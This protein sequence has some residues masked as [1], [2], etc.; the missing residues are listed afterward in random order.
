MDYDDDLNAPVWDDLNPP[1]QASDPG[2]RNTLADLS[3]NEDTTGQ[4][5]ESDK[6]NSDATNE[7][8]TWNNENDENEGNSNLLNELAPEEDPLLDLQTANG[9]S[10][11]SSP[12]KGTDDPLFSAS[13]Y[14][15]LIA[16]DEANGPD[17]SQSTPVLSSARKSGKPHM[18]FNSARMRRRP[19]T[20]KDRSPEIADPLGKLKKTSETQDELSEELTSTN[21]KSSARSKTILDQVEEPL[22]KVGSR[23]SIIENDLNTDNRQ[24]GIDVEPQ[25][26]LHESEHEE[27]TSQPVNFNIE[28][29]DPVKV[30]ELTSMHVEYTVV[31]ESDL[32]ETKYAQV[33]RRYT[34]F[35]WLYRQLQS[36]HWG[37]IIP[38]P[39]EK[40]S[41]GRFKQDFIENRRFQMEKM[42]RKIASNRSLQSDPDFILFLTSG[43]FTFDS[44]CR[45]HATGSNASR[46]S[47]DLSEIHISEIELLGAE[48]AAV[49]LKNGGLDGESQKRFL[50]ISFSSLPKYTESDEYF[51]EQ[52]KATENLEE[53]LKQLNKSLDLVDSER[54]ELA[55]VTEEFS[56]TI[57]ALAELEVTKQ[58]I[59][60]L[61]NFAET[62]RRI[63]ESLERSSLQESLTLG[64]TL[65][66]YI[67]SLA[68]VKAIFNQ[69]ARLGYYLVIVESDFSKKQALLE[70]LP[71][72]SSSQS[73]I[74]KISGAKK[75]HQVLQKRCKTVRKKWQEVGNYIKK[76]VAAFEIEK[77][78]DFRNSLEIFLESAIESQK[79]CIELWET[80]YQNNL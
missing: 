70:R 16:D 40:Q 41:V 47:N 58:N 22:F 29:K 45:E 20:Q 37:K 32:L 60:I 53:R 24:N 52:W 13:T 10:I 44:K 21:S 48:D 76:E 49:V 15:P 14:L 78:K 38:P 43:N 8:A 80:F 51:I 2:L 77:V 72:N 39:P 68:S 67:R 25:E 65:D 28:V 26:E 59:E 7:I 62:H 27:M 17:N 31:V 55:S 11:L 23:Q 69:R 75:E 73:N 66:E 5:H 64:V 50:S 34:D 30:G 4:Y 12:T 74:D 36:N 33:N 71:Q 1:N 46:D 63:R 56:K 19:L 61:T 79:E 6:P 54:N 57:D 18:L 9:V 3:L 42:L 35:R